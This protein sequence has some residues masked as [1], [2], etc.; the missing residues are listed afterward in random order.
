VTIAAN[1]F[2]IVVAVVRAIIDGVV[3][4]RVHLSTPEPDKDDVVTVQFK[5]KAPAMQQVHAKS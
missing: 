2:L 1:T 4:S 3:Q 5:I